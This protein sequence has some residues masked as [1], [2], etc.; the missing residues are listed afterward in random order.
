MIENVVESISKK[1]HTVPSFIYSTILQY[2]F[3]KIRDLSNEYLETHAN[4]EMHILI[5]IIT[6]HHNQYLILS[7]ILSLQNL[8]IIDFIKL[9]IVSL[10]FSYSIVYKH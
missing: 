4:Q 8:I 9:L 2:Y 1:Y 5:E 6:A 3:F 10:T 7:F